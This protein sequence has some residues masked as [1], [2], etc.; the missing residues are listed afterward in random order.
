MPCT[1]EHSS[2]FSHKRKNMP[3][4][5]EFFGFYIFVCNCFN[6]FSSVVYR[7][8]CGTTIT[9]QV[10]RY[11]KGSLMQYGV[12]VYHHFQIKFLGT[13]V[14]NRHTNKPSTMGDHKVNHFGG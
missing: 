7:N 1:S 11:C 9:Y 5:S 2:F 3:R 8:S 13:S 10:N 6:G 4:A 14:C 12:V